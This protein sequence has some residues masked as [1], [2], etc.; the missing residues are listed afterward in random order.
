MSGLYEGWQ[1]YTILCFTKNCC[2]SFDDSRTVN[3]RSPSNASRTRSMFA[4]VVSE[5]RPER[6]SLSTDVQPF[7][8]RLYHPHRVIRHTCNEDE[9]T[10]WASRTKQRGGQKSHRG[11][12]PRS[13]VSGGF[14]CPRRSGGIVFQSS[15]G[16][17]GLSVR[18][19]RVW[20]R[21]KVPGERVTEEAYAT[22]S[23]NQP[24]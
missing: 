23:W 17:C 7:L 10:R 22:L 21:M 15:S 4:G 3:R 1:S 19:A 11:L 9:R 13:C 2:T 14:D 8:N 12:H 16:W 20:P 5:G 6:G 24:P 18:L